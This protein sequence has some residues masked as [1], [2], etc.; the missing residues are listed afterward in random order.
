[1][2][3]FLT[4]VHLNS[5]ALQKLAPLIESM[6]KRSV[7]VDLGE[8]T[9]ES[10][11]IPY[12]ERHAGTSQYK[13]KLAEFVKNSI[14]PTGDKSS[15]EIEAAVDAAAPRYIFSAHYEKRTKK[16]EQADLLF[17]E[18]PSFLAQGL[19]GICTFTDEGIGQFYFGP[20]GSGAPLHYHYQAW[21]ALVYGKK[22]WVLVPPHQASFSN[23][24]AK[25]MVRRL[26]AEDVAAGKTMGGKLRCVQR[27]GD[28]VVVPTGWGHLTY[29]LATSIGVAKEFAISPTE[30]ADL[31]SKIAAMAAMATLQ[32]STRGAAPNARDHTSPPQRRTAPALQRGR[33]RNAAPTE[34]SGRTRESASPPS[35]PQLPG[36]SSSQPVR[37]RND[38]DTSSCPGPQAKQ[39]IGADT[40]VDVHASPR[41][42]AAPSI[43]KFPAGKG[44]INVG[45]FVVAV[46]DKGMSANEAT[47]RFLEGHSH[48]E[49]MTAMTGSVVAFAPKA[50]R[51][52][53]MAGGGACAAAS[54]KAIQRLFSVA[55]DACS[56]TAG[57][58]RSVDTSLMQQQQPTA[59]YDFKRYCEKRCYNKFQTLIEPIKMEYN[60]RG[61]DTVR[62]ADQGRVHKNFCAPMLHAIL[63]SCG[64]QNGTIATQLA[65]DYAVVGNT[66]IILKMLD[67]GYWIM[68]LEDLGAADSMSV[69]MTMVQWGHL[70]K[71]KDIMDAFPEL[72]TFKGPFGIP[73]NEMMEALT[74]SK[75]WLPPG[76]VGQIEAHTPGSVAA[77]YGTGGWPQ[78]EID[79]PGG[80]ADGVCEIAEVSGT[81]VAASPRDFIRNFI[82]M[83]R[84]VIVRDFVRHDANLKNLADL[85]SRSTLVRNHG[86]SEWPSASIPYPD[87]YTG[88]EAPA[89]TLR[90]FVD[91][92]VM[93]TAK[94]NRGADMLKLKNE[95]RA[96][97]PHYI[98]ADKTAHRNKD[99]RG[100]DDKLFPHVPKALVDGLDDLV[101]FRM[102]NSQFYLGAVGTGAPL[103]HHFGAWNAVVYGK[104]A[105]VLMPPGNASF[106]RMPAAEMV[107]RL[108]SEDAEAGY[109]VG[110]K[111][112]CVQNAGDMIVVPPHWGHLTYNLATSIG[113]A[114]EFMP[115]PMPRNRFMKDPN[116]GTARTHRRV[117]PKQRHEI[118]TDAIQAKDVLLAAVR[119]KHEQK[120]AATA[121]A[122]TA[123]AST[124]AASGGNLG[125]GPID[126][127]EFVRAVEA[128]SM[129]V[130]EVVV[131]FLAGHSQQEL[132]AA[133]MGAAS[134]LSADA[135][136]LAAAAGSGADGTC[137]AAP[138]SGVSKVFGAFRKR[139][140]SVDFKITVNQNLLAK[141]NSVPAALEGCP[142][143]LTKFKAAME[144][145][146]A[147]YHGRG[148]DTVYL[149][150]VFGIYKEVL[151]PTLD[152]LLDVCGSGRAAVD[153]L[154]IAR[155]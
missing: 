92:M 118:D 76:V 66:D 121:A 144:P 106:S 29:N 105:W 24:P 67:L 9:W 22:A 154:Q 57:F 82:L 59:P 34:G 56:F 37:S 143:C 25:E 54:R 12:A 4:L 98:F 70:D 60:A 133:V 141:S 123:A 73:P 152:A 61:Q 8:S 21:N 62:V 44:R 125:S 36:I 49:L 1:M 3:V 124:A 102:D 79:F 148:E 32:T 113:L 108:A 138:D 58:S 99:G 107:H 26:A 90:D 78:T 23:V 93:P 52:A 111:V 88:V 75:D 139:A 130:E 18:E 84:P 20:A 7:V 129:G 19:E 28:V 50:V 72:G 149:S 47:Q 51:L 119:P 115:S 16:R 122:S 142:N 85:F 53:A 153:V 104:K 5:C 86:N 112:R 74:A 127:K 114:K 94:S 71:A 14:V 134:G 15:D 101:S 136:R 132:M 95:I 83:Q 89:I 128:R 45:A 65:R 46:E 147:A 103:H 120:H 80:P 17:P 43:D 33:N 39:V 30:T 13:S 68:D 137:A 146:A 42:K 31:N 87:T 150:D 55:R 135:V 10:D 96:S 40:T 100:F 145:L 131:T 109:V 6:T 27:A 155:E 2:Q 77:P 91:D 69:L 140:Y 117:G 126:I 64:P 116:K 81:E 63:D 35:P 41:Q 11:S 151:Q 38:W 110:A 48:K 97:P